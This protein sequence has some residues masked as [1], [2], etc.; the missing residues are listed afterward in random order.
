MPRRRAIW[1]KLAGE[2]KPA[3]LEKLHKEHALEDVPGLV[4]EILA[5]KHAGRAVIAL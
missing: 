1:Q 3:A 2:W 4:K 5:G